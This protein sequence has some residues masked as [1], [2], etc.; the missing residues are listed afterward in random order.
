MT[1]RTGR[2]GART[3]NGSSAT[4]TR[5]DQLLAIAAQLFATRGYSQTTVRDIADEAGIL[6]GSLYHHFDSKE[7]MLREILQ[8]FMD[9]LLTGF[10]EIVS[11]GAPARKCLDELIHRAFATIHAKPYAVALYQN[12]SAH[13]ATMTDFAFVAKTSREIEK[14][15]I[16]VL[17]TGRDAGDFRADLEISLV[18]RFIRD[19]VWASVRWYNPRGR[20][21]HDVVASQYLV[22]LYGGILAG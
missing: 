5:R 13:V 10:T 16:S 3:A 20:F 6:S 2:N 19:T 15:W 8:E 9:D 1:A 18:Y 11:K 17:Q 4:A 21:K 12:E 14:L 7:T 22:M